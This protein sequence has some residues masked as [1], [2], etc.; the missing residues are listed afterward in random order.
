VPQKGDT[1]RGSPV[2]K[3]LFASL[4]G[5][6][7]AT[8]QLPRPDQ[9]LILIAVNRI[10]KGDH[11]MGGKM[12]TTTSAPSKGQ[13]SLAKIIYLSSSDSAVIAEIGAR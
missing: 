7:R 6:N 8:V 4:V 9:D 2:E 10:N 1:R 13:Y 5:S 11:A 3:S 12:D